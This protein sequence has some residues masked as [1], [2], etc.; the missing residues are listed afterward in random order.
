MN[1]TDGALGGVQTLLS[2][3]FQFGWLHLI[4]LVA[5]WERMGSKYDGGQGLAAFTFVAQMAPVLMMALFF[6]IALFEVAF[7]EPTPGP[8]V[9]ILAWG[10]L[11]VG[12]AML[13]ALVLNKA[14]LKAVPEMAL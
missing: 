2:L 7:N 14:P 9:M 4:G 12:P 3:G 10:A 8:I 6:P 13:L 5:G 1:S 11:G